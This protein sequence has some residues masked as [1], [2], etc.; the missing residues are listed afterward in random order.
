MK[1][2]E[3]LY[4]LLYLT[5]DE[6]WMSQPEIVESVQK[7]GKEIACKERSRRNFSNTKGVKVIDYADNVRLY[8][9]VTE[10]MKYEKLCRSSIT[11]HIKRKSQAK[12]GRRFFVIEDGNL[13]SQ[14]DDV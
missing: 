3:I 13:L 5:A 6:E 7:I 11:G 2:K 8:S 14:H 10:C 9:S 4:K 1:N 12:D